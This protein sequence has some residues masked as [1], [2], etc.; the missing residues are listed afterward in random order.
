VNY[1][2]ACGGFLK[3]IPLPK[4]PWAPAAT[5]SAQSRNRRV[6]IGTLIVGAMTAAVT[7]AT[8]ARDLVI[9]YRFGTA[10][11]VDAFFLALVLP[12][13]AVQVTAV[14]LA[15]AT[16]PQ[17]IKTREGGDGA[18]ADR[19]AANVGA[20]GLGLFALVA[21]L[22]AFAEE[23]ITRFLASGFSADKAATTR[24][25]YLALL[26]SIVIQGWSTFMGGLINAR[27][28]F[29]LVAAAPVLRPLAVIILVLSPAASGNSMVLVWG[30]LGGAILEAGAIGAAAIRLGIPV[31]SCWHGI[32]R[33]T[34]TVL[35][36]FGPLA[37]GFVVMGGAVMADQYLA[38]LLAPG[39]VAALSYGAKVVSLI[40]GLGVL[41]LSAVV[42]P[43]FSIQASRSQWR[44]L[45]TTLLQWS[46][47]VVA[48]GAPLALAAIV[49]SEPI[50]RLLFE[51]G[52]FSAADTAV[53]AQVQAFLLLQIPFY[54]PGILFTR[55]LMALQ[56][57]RLVMMVALTNVTANIG[58]S[59]VLLHSFGV[60]G[61]AVGISL[62]YALA[63]SSSGYF[64]FS[65]L[66]SATRREHENHA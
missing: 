44:E 1:L 24:S 57:G 37:A 31:L 4:L 42:L 11:A 27:E 48:L 64:V 36:E 7:A 46:G 52:A 16:M 65:R 13:I 41:P 2:I 43:H 10:D 51:R 66:K 29:A 9:A 26:P 53:V 5:W 49:Y 61:I 22:L 18:A 59:L 60:I 63:L 15:T 34:R 62:G 20:V 50:V 56:E 45:R 6:L 55:V 28:R 12:T 3:G 40:I 19:L 35:R 14:A 30:Y 32:D 38:S 21:I 23:P 17:L 25:F 47:A 33:P 54:L 58:A 39:S 8:A